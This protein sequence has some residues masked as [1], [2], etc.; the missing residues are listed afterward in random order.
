MTDKIVVRPEREEDF[1]EIFEVNRLAFGQDGE[2]KLVDTLRKNRAVFNS[3]L[4]IVA[5]QNNTMVGH[6]LFTIISIIDNKGNMYESLALAPMAVKPGFQKKGIGGQLIKEGLGAAKK[7][8][9]KSVIVLGHEEY[10]PKFGFEPAEK[11]NIRAPFDIPSSNFMAIELVN[12]GLKNTSGTVAYPKE[13][14]S[15]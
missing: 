10:Y 12:E 3:Q 11:W 5:I 13:F 15:V 6:I 9:F 7:L 8:G 2:A 1:H 4:S 14:E